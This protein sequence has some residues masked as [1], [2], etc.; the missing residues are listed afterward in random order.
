MRVW[1]AMSH[2]LGVMLGGG[3]GVHVAVGGHQFC[4]FKLHYSRT[5]KTIAPKTGVFHGDGT[6]KGVSKPMF[7]LDPRFEE[8]Y[9]LPKS[10]FM[11]SQS[12]T[13]V[14]TTS[15]I[16]EE[17]LLSQ[18]RVRQILKDII[19]TI[20]ESL[21][22]DQTYDLDFGFCRVHLSKKGS[23]AMFS[24]TFQNT[25]REYDVRRGMRERSARGGI[26]R[27]RLFSPGWESNLD[28]YVGHHTPARS[29]SVGSRRSES[30]ERPWR[31]RSV[32]RTTSRSS[33]IP[34]SPNTNS[35][36]AAFY[37]SWKTGRTFA[38]IK[39]QDE[40]A[41]E[42]QEIARKSREKGHRK[43]ML[44][45]KTAPINQPYNKKPAF[46][47][48]VDPAE[49]V[50]NLVEEVRAE[51]ERNYNTQVI[52]EGALFPNSPRATVSCPRKKVDIPPAPSPAPNPH[53]PS[54]MKEESTDTSDLNKIDCR[55]QSKP[56]PSTSTMF[57]FFKDEKDDRD[58]KRKQAQQ[59]EQW[60][61]RVAA[62]KKRQ[63]EEQ[64]KKDL[65][66]EL[67]IIERTACDSVPRRS[68]IRHF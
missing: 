45:K 15:V 43:P 55:V 49:S 22:R 65:E 46:T 19:T 25:L 52:E 17:L 53:P 57:L 68:G 62:E 40:A 38:D 24:N 34:P 48:H 67:R 44:G 51:E 56:Q 42:H 50:S 63:K 9:A 5:D 13:V 10:N 54:P 32:E 35:K 36:H 8:R 61:L 27:H 37:T 66:L 4:Y 64:E 21:F 60:N 18:E 31:E 28:L 23:Q 16:A 39:K 1:K 59:T 47:V 2:Y 41:C 11:I 12:P 33:S 7:K 6:A 29:S 3:R 30:R 14:L 58:R 26:E 20:G